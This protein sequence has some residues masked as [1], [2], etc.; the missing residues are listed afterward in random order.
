M[1]TISILGTLAAATLLALSA[2][3][4]AAP[5]VAARIDGQPLLAFSVD[6]SLRMARMS[7][8]NA[9]RNSTLDTLVANRL[10]AE[11]ARRRFAE[12][13]LAPG[14]LVGFARAVAV[15]EQLQ[16]TLRTLYGKELEEE[17]RRLPGAS[18]DALVFE[19]MTPV[20]A[21]LDAVLGKPGQPRLDSNFSQAAFDAARKVG[22][23]RYALPSGPRG[24]ITLHDVAQRQN[25]QGRVA[26]FA[27][28]RAF[29]HQQAMAL[30][31]ALYVLDW[32]ARRFGQA[33]VD[34]LRRTLVDRDDALAL[35]RLH[36]VG[37]D[38]HGGN[39]MLDALARQVSKGQVR[40]YY[41]RHR[42][43]FV[44]IERVRARHIRVAGEAAAKEIFAA[45]EGGA[46]FGAMA[47]ARSLAGDAASGG[48]LG[49]VQHGGTPGW[50]AQLLFAQ[51]PG[52]L[53]PP[54]RMPGGPDENPAWEIVLVTERVQGYQDPESESVRYVASRAVARELAVSRLGALRREVLRKARV[55][56]APS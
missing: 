36:G 7:D 29:M 49:W 47:R 28:D 41:R 17:L 26:L 42:E 40:D 50:L 56:V 45:L 9:T 33:A 44:R 46:D 52:R 1:K 43:Q 53:S 15:D 51:A 11:A 19:K 18:L 12:T 5:Q 24:T 37:D 4:G 34:D 3:A 31:A 20:D 13:E 54:V 35:Q 32:S 14:Q 21:A 2:S 6:A 25:V 22:L 27:R 55:E 30:L 16:A 10:L 39:A 23:L 8:P 38:Q 48:E